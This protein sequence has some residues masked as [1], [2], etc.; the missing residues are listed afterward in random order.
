VECIERAMA[1]AQ[2][3]A[4]LS[5]RRPHD[6]ERLEGAGR[7]EPEA[8]WVKRG[9]GVTDYKPPPGKSDGVMQE[10]CVGERTTGL[11]QAYA[12]PIWTVAPELAGERAWCVDEAHEQDI[13]RMASWRRAGALRA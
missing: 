8:E 10:I 3:R 12:P 4:P 2:W 1:P 7:D 13:R 6:Y 5:P 11:V 9:E